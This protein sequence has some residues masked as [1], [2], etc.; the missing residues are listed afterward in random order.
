M[1]ASVAD[2]SALAK[3]DFSGW[4]P[5]KNFDLILQLDQVDPRLRPGMSATA[6]V[7]AERL[8]NSLLIPAEAAFQKDGRSVVYV[9][10]GSRFEERPI[11]ISRRSTTQILVATG[12]KSGERVALKDPTLTETTGKG[13]AK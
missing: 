3:L 9:L 13:A 7:A 4:P 8:K 11:L 2:I 10:N 12:V 5:A 6:R 1:S